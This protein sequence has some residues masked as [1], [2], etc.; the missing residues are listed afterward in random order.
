MLNSKKWLFDG[1]IVSLRPDASGFDCSYRKSVEVYN[2]TIITIIQSHNLTVT[3]M[4]F[5]HFYIAFIISFIGSLPLGVLNLTIVEIS[6]KRTLI[7]AFYFALAAA[8]VEFVQAFIAIK[9]STLFADNPSLEYWLR[10]N[11]LAVEVVK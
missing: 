4:Y 10:L 1:V 6:I 3:K 8:L 5:D 2:Y 9:F 7:H 11:L